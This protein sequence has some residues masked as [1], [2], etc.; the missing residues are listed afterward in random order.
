MMEIL[1]QVETREALAKIEEIAKTKKIDG[2][3]VR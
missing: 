1:V 3:T 2:R